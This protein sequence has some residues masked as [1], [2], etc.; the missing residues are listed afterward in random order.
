MPNLQQRCL[1][2]AILITVWLV[3]GASAHA[4]NAYPQ[5]PIKII[6]PVAAGGGTDFVAR[7]VGQKL[8][9]TLST[10]VIIENK[11]GGGGNVGVDIAAKSEPDGYTLVM[12]ITSFPVNPGLYRKL[13]FDTQKDFAPITLVA[14]APLL[15]VI[16]AQLPV[17]SLAD[18]IKLAKDK[19]GALNYATSGVGTTSHLA[20]ELFKFTSGLDIV[21]VPYKGGGPAVTDLIAG[22][23][24]MYFS[25]VPA[26]LPQVKA[27]KIRSLAV[28]SSKRVPS[29]SDVPTVAE[30]G[31]PG[32]EV[33]GWF[34]LFAPAKTPAAIVER[35][36]VEVVKI[37]QMPDVREKIEAH[38]LLP[39]GGTS[40]ELGVFLDTEIKKWTHL[41][42]AA[43][44]TQQ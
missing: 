16:N 8:G 32:Y 26:A 39:G 29:L 44:I 40:K 34:G 11:P 25:T 9:E 12:P 5:K 15:L 6:V 23:V 3:S 18:L 30:A 22:S 37:L 38:G 28:T 31:L 14:S 2:L 19:P 43:N 17:Q 20:A 13:P 33:V 27:G 1:T 21:N 10:P 35:L 4:Q 24:Q 7:V 42:Q 41:I 36:N